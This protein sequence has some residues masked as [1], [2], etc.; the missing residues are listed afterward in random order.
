MIKIDE[1]YLHENED[2]DNKL[3]KVSFLQTNFRRSTFDNK[4]PLITL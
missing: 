4:V 2:S 3:T 1:K